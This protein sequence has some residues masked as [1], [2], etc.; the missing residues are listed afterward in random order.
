MKHNYLIKFIVAFVLL[1]TGFVGHAQTNYSVS[2]IP[3]QV[4]VLP[5]QAV[6]SSMDDQYS[7]VINIGFGFTYFGNTYDQMI[8]STNGFIDFRTSLAGT[9]S[10]WQVSGA[11]PNTSVAIKNSIMGCFHDMNNGVMNVVSGAISYAL[12]GSAPY[13]KFVLIF[14][15]QPHYQC[16]NLK[17]TFQVV[18]Y[19]TLNTIDVQIVNKPT[20]TTWNAGKATI[21]IVNEP[22]TIAIVPAGRNNS[23]WTATQEG[24][25]F[26]LPQIAQANTFIFCDIDNDGT[27]TYD[28]T[29]LYSGSVGTTSYYQSLA[30]AQDAVNALPTAYTMV[31]GASQA[32]F[33]LNDGV[34]TQLNLSVIDCSVDYD[35]DG[36]PTVAEDLNGD[37]NLANDDTDGDGIPNFLDNDDDGDMILTSVEYVFAN[38]GRNATTNTL[39]D[40]DGDGIPNYLD[41]DDDGDGVLTINE[42]Y[43]Q[44]N[45]PADDD[46]N[47]NGL[48][49]YLE[50]DVA[51]GVKGHKLESMISLYPNPASTVLNIENKSGETINSVSIYSVT[52]ALVKEIK[53]VDNV[54][55][56]SVS[57]LQN[58]IYFVKLQSGNQV[59]NSKFIKK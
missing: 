3:H 28:L 37:G 13:R 6:I 51:L 33:A 1:I 59:M 9:T 38:Q 14:D 41:D 29:A 21:G 20:C 5:N 31:S 10:P 18:L 53:N 7:N 57:D 34:I 42:D 32:I 2:P 55:S 43:D 24:W 45:N 35:L 44:N 40:T 23:A 11:F 27:E 8:V 22:G 12:V 4:Y 17:S 39:R 25:R 56:I 46:T 15:D 54:Q 50:Y 30:D 47:N 19:E 36:V 26:Q 58:G 16:T 52:G 49:D 48:P